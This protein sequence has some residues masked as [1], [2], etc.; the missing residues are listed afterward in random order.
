MEV[1]DFSRLETL[2]DSL[3]VYRDEVASGKRNRSAAYEVA[4][5][6]GKPVR[7]GDRIAYYITGNDPSARSFENCKPAEE[8]D[9]NFPDENVP[10]YLRRL[11]EF[12]EKFAE[13]F[14]P[15]DFRAIFSAEGLFPFDPGSITLLITDV[16]EKK[17]ESTEDTP[18][19]RPGIWL[20]D[21]K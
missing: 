16:R 12:S 9:P 6:G 20:D 14:N 15:A 18:Q 11:D 3:D 21:V 8:W 7:P 1:R 10:Y 4:L 5:N 17:T 19:V 13:F 2:K